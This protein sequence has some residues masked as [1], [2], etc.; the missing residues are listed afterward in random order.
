MDPAT[1]ALIAGL[2][3]LSEK[4]IPIIRDA[5]KNGDIPDDEADAWRGK[6]NALRA[7]HGEAYSGPE[8]EL[9]GR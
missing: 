1:L 4:A 2:I 6:Y 7:L 8:Y 3:T 9:S 5:F